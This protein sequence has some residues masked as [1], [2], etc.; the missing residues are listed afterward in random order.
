L[1]Q[2]GDAVSQPKHRSITVRLPRATDDSGS[3]PGRARLESIYSRPVDK[4]PLDALP[5]AFR[6]VMPRR[7]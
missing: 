4:R 3:G 1:A 7:S 2:L 5:A 6:E